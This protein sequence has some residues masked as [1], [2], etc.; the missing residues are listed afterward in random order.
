MNTRREVTNKLEEAG[1]N[2]D[3]VG[4]F[5]VDRLTERVDSAVI[6]TGFWDIVDDVLTE[7]RCT[8]LIPQFEQEG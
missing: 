6:E 4:R 2:P 8:G 7:A 1:V 3:A 5:V